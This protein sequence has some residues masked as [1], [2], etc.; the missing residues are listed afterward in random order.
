MAQGR[1]DEEKATFI[2][3]FQTAL[4]VQEGQK[5]LEEDEAHRRKILVQVLAE[6]KGLGEGSEKGAL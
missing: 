5:P 4:T 2:Q 3:P 1:T 6:V